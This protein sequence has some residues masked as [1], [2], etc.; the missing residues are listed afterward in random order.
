MRIVFQFD[1]QKVGLF[2]NLHRGAL[3]AQCAYGEHE[4]RLL[5]NGKLTFSVA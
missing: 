3:V 5:V 2:V 1:F 4:S